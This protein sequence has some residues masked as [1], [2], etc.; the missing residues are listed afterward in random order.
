[1]VVS[2]Y[3]I[4]SLAVSKWNSSPVLRREKIARARAHESIAVADLPSDWDWRNVN[5]TNFVTE[6]RNQHIPQCTTC[7]ARV[8]CGVALYPAC[9]RAL[10]PR[11]VN[12]AMRIA[13]CRLWFMLGVRHPVNAE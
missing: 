7:A 10:S 4:I 9:A 13:S 12:L 2:V 11:G 8:L 1:M 3:V 5:G 6:S